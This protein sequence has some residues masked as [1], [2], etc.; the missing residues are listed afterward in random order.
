VTYGQIATRL[1][2]PSAARAAGRAMWHC[3]AGVPWQRVV[4]ARGGISPRPNLE[5]MLRQRRVLE[6]EG[7]RL[8]RGRVDLRRFAWWDGGRRPSAVTGTAVAR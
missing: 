1:G 4:N 3:P 5:G 8:A 6:Q 7:V 2:T